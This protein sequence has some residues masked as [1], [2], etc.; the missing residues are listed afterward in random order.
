M[1]HS[2]ILYSVHIY[3]ILRMYICYFYY[4]FYVH[5]SNLIIH[6]KIKTFFMNVPILYNIIT[7]T[8]LKTT[9]NNA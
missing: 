5:F 6:R 8:Q 7:S 3:T 9:T 1:Q 2:N 4:N